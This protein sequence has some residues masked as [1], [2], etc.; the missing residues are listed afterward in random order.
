MGQVPA[1]G[2]LL[3]VSQNSSRFN[4]TGCEGLRGFSERGGVREEP[5]TFEVCIVLKDCDFDF[6]YGVLQQAQ[7]FEKAKSNHWPRRV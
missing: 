2:W 5:Q 3:P 4:K 6:C 7:G 1:H